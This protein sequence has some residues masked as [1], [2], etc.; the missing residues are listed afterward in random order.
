MVAPI[1]SNFRFAAESPGLVAWRKTLRGPA[2][3]PVQGICPC[4]RDRGQLTRA[5]V[6]FNAGHTHLI[7]LGRPMRAV[8]VAVGGQAKAGTP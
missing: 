5:V 4:C 2:L 8:F 3:K 1:K 7:C 6:V